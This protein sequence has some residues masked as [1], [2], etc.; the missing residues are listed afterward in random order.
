MDHEY[1]NMFQHRG[2]HHEQMHKQVVF[3][4]VWLGSSCVTRAF[5]PIMTGVAV[6]PTLIRDSLESCSG[7]MASWKSHI[8][9][10]L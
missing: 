2:K 1:L 7:A 5:P 10:R 6:R 8:N 9:W 4:R 3:R